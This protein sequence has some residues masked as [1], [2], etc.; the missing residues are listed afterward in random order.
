MPRAPKPP[1]S[2]RPTTRRS[3]RLNKLQ[4]LKGVSALEADQ[5]S[6]PKRRKV[7]SNA[8]A[9]FCQSGSS[10]STVKL[11]TT[12]DL[13]RSQ[14]ITP[15]ELV[16]REKAIFALEQAY[17][18]REIELDDR[19]LSLQKKEHEASLMMSQI[20]QREAQATLSQLEEHFTC[21]LCYEILAY[22]YTLN[23]GQCGHTFC[24]ICILKWF[25][26]RL[27][28]HCGAWHES[29]DCPIC[30][31]LL[32]I[33]PDRV[34]RP[35]I[36]FPFVPNRTAAAVCESLIKKL[37]NSPSC[38][39]VVKREDSEGVWASGSWATGCGRKKDA[40]KEA[41]EIGENADVA[42]WREG[43]ITRAEWL[44]K[45]REGKKEMNYISKHWATLTSN[46]FRFMKQKLG[47]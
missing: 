26:S 28:I 11:H 45:D 15:A 16:R 42:A 10:T 1:S 9:S 31:S 17:K 25:F 43:G 44:K 21:A 4:D 2:P 18:L 33:T 3:S 19:L 13:R 38:G 34:P 27:H 20:D 30:R 46:D 39:L 41:E 36:T 29:V 32:V 7:T 37:A 22:P 12:S 5:H 6:K 47:V 24:A 40:S 23:P 8:S 14:R 35:D